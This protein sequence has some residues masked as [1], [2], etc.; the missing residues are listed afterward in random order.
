MK[1]IILS[2]VISFVVSFSLYSQNESGIVGINRS[3]SPFDYFLGKIDL[4][5]SQI[6]NISNTPLSGFGGFGSQY[7]PAIDPIGNRYFI[8]SNSTLFIIDIN[9]GVVLNTY[10]INVDDLWY[11]QY[12]IMDSTLYAINRTTSPFE[13]FLGK[14]DLNNGQ[15]SN[16]ST[17]LPPSFGSFGGQYSP[18][19]DPIGNRY[20]IVSNSTL[21]I[22]DL[23]TGVVL[24]THNINIDDLWYMQY[25]IMD[26]TLYAIN[27][28]TS[29]FEYFLGKIDLNS[30]QISN[31]SN[32]PLSGFGGFGGQY[33]P[34][35]D[36]IGNRYFIV[37]NS[38]LF[39][40]DINTGVV[41]NTSTINVDDLW[42][43][44]YNY[45]DNQKNADNDS[46]IVIPNVFT[47]NQDGLNDL[48][49][50]TVGKHISSIK[51]TIY[52]RWGILTYKSNSLNEGWDGRTTAGIKVSEGTYFYIIE[53]TSKENGNSITYKGALTL[54]R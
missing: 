32:T 12:N 13:Y 35:I 5:N 52:N 4:N 49:K 54:I 16:I 40:I 23:S 9:T 6:S 47:P 10:A 20:F 8:I 7:S 19:I 25:N 30:G 29:P 15:I 45:N 53:T 1:K 31:I 14:I 39:S 27:R 11:M 34:A 22:I 42:Y 18:A 24:N 50:P 46:L 43:M 41:L 21:F 48:F 33:S 37:S 28:T 26:S 44:Q 17:A 2:F 51:T 38:T 36:P 3:T